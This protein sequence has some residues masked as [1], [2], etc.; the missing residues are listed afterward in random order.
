[1]LG[2]SLL[3]ALNENTTGSLKLLLIVLGVLAIG[4]IVVKN[5][6]LPPWV[7]QILLVVCL[8]VFGI[9]AISFLM[10]L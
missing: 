10:A 2:I 4:Y 1:M 8:V 9:I 7:V 3:A 5:L 6:D